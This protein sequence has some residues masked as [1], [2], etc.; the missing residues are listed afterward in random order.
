M[1][2]PTII[3]TTGDQNSMLWSNSASI[4]QE[5]SNNDNAATKW[6]DLHYGKKHVSFCSFLLR[7]LFSFVIETA[8]FL[9]YLRWYL[10]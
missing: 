6:M 9:L 7:L 1:A 10:L 5:E 2:K 3:S 4:T 8:Y